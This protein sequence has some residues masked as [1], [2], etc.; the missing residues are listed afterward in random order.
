[1]INRS[2]SVALVLIAVCGVWPRSAMAH[3]IDLFAKAVGDEI[4]GR[5]T[6]GDGSPVVGST[7]EISWNALD[8]SH[9]AD[10]HSATVQTNDAG[11]F[12]F[13]PRANAEHLFICRTADGHRAAFSVQ[14]G[15]GA[16]EDVSNSIDEKIDESVQ[17][18]IGALQEQL[19]AYERQTRLRDVLGGIGYILGLAGVVALIKTRR[20]SS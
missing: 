4:H 5:V 3:S 13:K 20:R 8:T 18:Y 7:I 9:E 14:F 16:D 1:M 6:Y 19:H 11:E 10:E 2:R 12:R 15:A 17:R